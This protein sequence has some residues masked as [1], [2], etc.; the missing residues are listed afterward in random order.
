MTVYYEPTLVNTYLLAS[1]Y[2][3]NLKHSAIDNVKEAEFENGDI[4]IG[5]G[6]RKG[7]L[8]GVNI[9][10]YNYITGIGDTKNG[11]DDMIDFCMPKDN[12]L[13]SHLKE[14]SD[15]LEAL[16]GAYY[17][18]A[19]KYIQDSPQKTI[20]ENIDVVY[21]YSNRLTEYKEYV[22]G[23]KPAKGNIK[24]LR[25]GKY[26]YKLSEEGI[27]YAVITNKKDKVFL[28]VYGYN[29]LVVEEKL[30]IKLTRY[31]SG[32]YIFFDTEMRDVSIDTLESIINS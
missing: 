23:I 11:V 5:F 13:N 15:L 12:W 2:F 27:T 17:H 19:Y 32:D 18:S 25:S 10:G 29:P 4:L 3:Y 26:A 20:N 8:P 22:A 24:I 9:I 1:K 6:F 14:R 30:G 28:G 7:S 21:A 16:Y 31:D